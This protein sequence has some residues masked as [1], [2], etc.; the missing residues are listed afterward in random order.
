MTTRAATVLFTAVIAVRATAF[1]FSKLLLVDM[2][3]FTL[4]G[5]RFLLAFALLAIVFRRQ[6]RAM[7]RT[8]FLHG[9]LLGVL[10]FVV[11]GFE[12]CSLTMAASST[13]SFLE[14]TAI[15]FVPLAE[16]FMARALPT[17]KA[18]VCTIVVMV[19]V[20]F[21]TLGD[22]ALSF[23]MGE[24]LAM[25]AAL[26]YTVVIIVTARVSRESDA[27][28]LG[29]MQ[30][31]FIG[32]FGVATAFIVEQPVM[33]SGTLQ[34]VY[35]AI[36]VVA[37]TGFGFTFQP[38]AQRYISAQRASLLLAVSPL[39]AG[40]LGIVVLGEPFGPQTLLGMALIIGG[41]LAT[42]FKGRS[43]GPTDGTDEPKETRL[44]AGE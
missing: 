28:C 34:W 36:L 38:L 18:V 12:L 17:G 44:S 39:V 21:V 9:L 29:V 11:M 24:A 3:P 43:E 31:G 32:L 13:V 6:L 25:G 14:N 10:F 37:C 5:L 42:S 40:V 22:G 30:V 23:E 16:A 35:L 1:L 2:G 8:A 26:V 41:I 7:T 20:G 4:M 19:G 27:T 33:P 15:V